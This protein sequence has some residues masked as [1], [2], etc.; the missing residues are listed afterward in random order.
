M[1]ATGSRAGAAV[2]GGGAVA[3]DDAPAVAPAAGAPEPAVRPV[4]AREDPAAPGDGAGAAVAAASGVAGS[5][6]AGSVAAGAWASVA[7][8]SVSVSCPTEPAGSLRE[9]STK[10]TAPPRPASRN[11]PSAATPT[12]RPVRLFAAASDAGAATAG[13][14]D[15]RAAGGSGGGF[16]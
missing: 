16:G 5:T 12:S 1:S 2:T 10:N 4:A 6:G 8:G 13:P 15:G 9:R 14:A 3:E 11:S 7:G